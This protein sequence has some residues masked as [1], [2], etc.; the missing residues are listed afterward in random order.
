MQSRCDGKIGVDQ[1]EPDLICFIVDSSLKIWTILRNSRIS[2]KHGSGT[3]PGTIG[4][5]EFCK[6][7]HLKARSGDWN[8]V[9]KSRGV[10]SFYVGQLESSCWSD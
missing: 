1:T 8:F 5:L 2:G 3:V 10:Q 9:L 6:T 7:N 4:P